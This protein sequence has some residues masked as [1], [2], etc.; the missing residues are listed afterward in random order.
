MFSPPPPGAPEEFEPW[1]PEHSKNLCSHRTLPISSYSCTSFFHIV[2]VVQLWCWISKML[3]RKCVNKKFAI[4][5]KKACN[6]GRLE[7]E[8]MSPTWTAKCCNQTV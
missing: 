7:T 1:V 3:I 4:V 6:I 8:T 5:M 2:I